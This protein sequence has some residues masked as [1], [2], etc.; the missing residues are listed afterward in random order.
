MTLSLNPQQTTGHPQGQPVVC[1]IRPL[2]E[3]FSQYQ[4]ANSLYNVTLWYTFLPFF[5]MIPFSTSA[6]GRVMAA[7][8]AAMVEGPVTAMCPA[9]VLQMHPKA[10]IVIDESA[11]IV[12]NAHELPTGF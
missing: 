11:N 2:A 5:T 8:V 1:C 10:F 12:Y 3:L 6:A 4:L 7:A 9:S